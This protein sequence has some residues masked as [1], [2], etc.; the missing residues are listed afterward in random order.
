MKLGLGLSLSSMQRRRDTPFT[1]A[2]LF[3]ASEPGVWLDPD[4]PAT[5]F[6]D[7]AGTTQAQI[8][9]PVALVLDKSKGLELGAELV[10]LSS[11]NLP[12][13]AAIVDN[14]LVWDGVSI[15]AQSFDNISGGGAY[16]F[17]FTIESVTNTT[18]TPLLHNGNAVGA[19]RSSAGT[20]TELL[21]GSA[22]T[23]RISLRSAGDGIAVISGI[24]VKRLPGN[25]ATQ[26]TLS[27]RP[28]LRE[29]NGLRYLE[30]D[31]VDD[32]LVTPTITPGTDKVQVFAGVRKFSLDQQTILEL[33]PSRNSNNGS[34]DLRATDT[35]YN[36][37]ARGDA[38]AAGGQIA[39]VD[40]DA[41]PSTNVLTCLHDI[42]GNL[43]V[44]RNSG[45]SGS[46]ATG[47]KGAGNFLA[48]PVFIG[49]RSGSTLFFEG[50]IYS[51]T[52]RFGPNLDD[53]TIERTEHYI[54]KRTG[55]SL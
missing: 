15:G 34:F 9:D 22:G 23:S 45:V 32:S 30:F 3:A 28:I 7:T 18:V 20:Y 26:P 8:G 53:P 1:P 43:S 51:L 44:L 42:A 4:D 21:I 46:P 19:G 41:S 13:G 25:H 38:S 5:L 47:D 10:D 52:V 49:S 6:S 36:G 33:S 24:S 55:V 54:A 16:L 2:A 11:W 17:T 39:R 31:G 48:Y 29:S 50:R 37:L 40:S 12:S 27:S 14:K 35:E